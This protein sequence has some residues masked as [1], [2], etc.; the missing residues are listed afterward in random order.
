MSVYGRSG[1]TALITVGIGL[2]LHFLMPLNDKMFVK[3]IIDGVA[4]VVVYFTC[5]F[6][7]TFNRQERAHY[8]NIIFEILHIKKRFDENA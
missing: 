7:I 8:A 1:I 5:T 2:G 4:V 3:L 6:L